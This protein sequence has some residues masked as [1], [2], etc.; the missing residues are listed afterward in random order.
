MEQYGKIINQ[1][2]FHY[3]LNMEKLIIN[4][5]YYHASSIFQDFIDENAVEEYVD[6][7]IEQRNIRKEKIK[8]KGYRKISVFIEGY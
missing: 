2:K 7:E 3:Q 8:R 5:V 4:T 1:R 6:R